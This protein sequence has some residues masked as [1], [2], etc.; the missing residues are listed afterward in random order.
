MNASLADSLGISANESLKTKIPL[1][2]IVQFAERLQAQNLEVSCIS[3]YQGK[4][5]LQKLKQEN[6]VLRNQCNGYDSVIL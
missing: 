5:E 6:M 2:Q 3:K 1:R 4:A